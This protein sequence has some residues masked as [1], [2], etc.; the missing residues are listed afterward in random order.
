MCCVAA[1]SPPVHPPVLVLHR[2]GG[3]SVRFAHSLLS[4]RHPTPQVERWPEYVFAGGENTKCFL[5]G[6]APLPSASHVNPNAA[7]ELPVPLLAA[8]TTSVECAT[9]DACAEGVVAQDAESLL[10]AAEAAAPG[11]LQLPDGIKLLANTKVRACPVLV[12]RHGR[13]KIREGKMPGSGLGW[14][15]RAIDGTC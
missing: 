4:F 10:K 5:C 8:E 11:P 13:V 1:A 2:E 7:A 15:G 14:M 12:L 3:G 9:S 6:L